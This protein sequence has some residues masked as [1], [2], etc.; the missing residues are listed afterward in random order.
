MESYNHD[1]PTVCGKRAIE[2]VLKESHIIDARVMLAINNMR[3]EDYLESFESDNKSN[4]PECQ[5][6]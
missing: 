1:K 4:S 3:E 6:G 2:R 5:G